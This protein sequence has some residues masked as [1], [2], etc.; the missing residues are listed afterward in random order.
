MAERAS[1]RD[2]FASGT[3]LSVPPPSGGPRTI[4]W[5]RMGAEAY[6]RPGRGRVSHRCA[7]F[8][9]EGRTAHPGVF[10]LPIGVL[11][12]GSGADKQVYPHLVGALEVDQ[13]I[14]EDVD[15]RH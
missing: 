11:M 12:N 5:P 10:E 14:L 3:S 1:W 13:Q 2:A 7:E 4:T 8:R 9:D 6:A 15:G